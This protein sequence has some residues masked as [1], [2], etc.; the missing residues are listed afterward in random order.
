LFV[1]FYKTTFVDQLTNT[2]QVWVAMQKKFKLSMF[3]PNS[4]QSFQQ[5]FRIWDM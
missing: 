4:Q 5:L 3:S 2:F 1:D